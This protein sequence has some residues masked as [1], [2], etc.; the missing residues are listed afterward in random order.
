MKPRLVAT[1]ALRGWRG[2]VMCGLLLLCASGAWGHGGH[3]D[4]DI[5]G[6]VVPVLGSLP[7]GLKGLRVQLRET[8][9]PQLI[10]TNPT[11]KTLTVYDTQGR[12]F[13]RI[14]DG[15][16]KGDLGAAAF[17]RSY[18]LMAP[19]SIPA[20]AS[21]EPHWQVVESKPHWGW[22]DLRLRTGQVEVP[23]DIAQAGKRARVGQWSIPVKLGAT[24]TRISGYFA[25]VPTPHGIA[26]ARIRDRGA[27]T[28]KALVR[29]MA[30]TRPGVFLLYR[31]DKPLTVMGQYGEPFLRF[32]SEKVK[33]NR[34]S[35]TWAQV[36]SAGKPKPLPA[37]KGSKPRWAQVSRSSGYGWIEP[38]AAFSG[39]VSNPRQSNI[40]KHW[41]IPVRIGDRQSTIRGVTL[42]VPVKSG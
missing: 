19:A 37:A 38:R 26:Q 18:T 21:I 1:P 28:D 27:L 30:G 23:H 39:T 34:R 6:S 9:A 12:A 20:D 42:W 33:V 2:F 41:K 5:P 17:H 24:R 15:R 31:G 36:A 29:A 4:S 40:V 8:L 14:G 10:I 11:D 22:F 3:H 16:V 13:L 7:E 32:T 35:A 25:F